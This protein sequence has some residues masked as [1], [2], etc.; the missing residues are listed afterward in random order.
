[1]PSG[2]RAAPRSVRPR[3][4]TGLVLALVLGTAGFAVMG[5]TRQWLVGLLA[6][7]AGPQTADCPS[8]LEAGKR[9]L[10]VA[11]T[12][13]AHWHAHVQA[14]TDL[15]SGENTAAE[16][17]AIW[18]RTRLAG[19]R[20]LR[21]FDRADRVYRRAARPACSR[22]SADH[23]QHVGT[24][25]SCPEREQL[26]ARAVAAARAAIGDWESHQDNMAAFD[27]HEF[28][29]G[30]AQRMWVRAWSTAPAN[31]NAFH[32]AIRRLHQAPPCP[33]T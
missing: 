24:A 5:P 18:S 26:T 27:N 20:D 13:V 23:G 25:A 21:R 14:R 3:L 29:A 1:M 28:G 19:P 17:D 7:A 9:T 2:K 22:Q 12:G 11:R 32:D 10:R 30:H 33:R 15:L 6:A 4:V 16:T 31:I 8:E